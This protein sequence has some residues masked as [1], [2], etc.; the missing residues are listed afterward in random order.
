MQP[1]K[2]LLP[3]LGST[4]DRGNRRPEGLH[5]VASGP[6]CAVVNIGNGSVTHIWTY[7][8]RMRKAQLTYKAE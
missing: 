2:D 1:L 4:Y 6:A 8:E 5:A 7:D 3:D